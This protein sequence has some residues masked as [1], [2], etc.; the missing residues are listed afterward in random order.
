MED[1]ILFRE[2]RE[3]SGKVPKKIDSVFINEDHEKILQVRLQQIVAK[4]GNFWG[5]L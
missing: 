5:K 4:I 1:Q 3:L 2:S